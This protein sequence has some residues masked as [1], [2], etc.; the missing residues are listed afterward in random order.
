MLIRV[1]G[2]IKWFAIKDGNFQPAFTTEILVTA[3]GN[4]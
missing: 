1:L 3:E 4:L 2:D